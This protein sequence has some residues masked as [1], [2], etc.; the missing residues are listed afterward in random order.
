MLDYHEALVRPYQTL[1]GLL[2]LRNLLPQTALSQICQDSSMVMP[3]AR[4][5]S[6]ARPDLPRISMATDAGLMLAPA[7][8]PE[9]G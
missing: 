9:A 4:S 5:S 7:A 2:Q 6:I 3:A 1:Q 8:S